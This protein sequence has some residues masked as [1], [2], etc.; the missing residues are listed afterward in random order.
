MPIVPLFLGIIPSLAARYQAINL[1]LLIDLFQTVVTQFPSCMQLPACNDF[2][3]VLLDERVARGM[4]ELQHGDPLSIHVVEERRERDRINGFLDIFCFP[5]SISSWRLVS[6]FEHLRPVR[7]LL[8]LPFPPCVFS[9]FYGSPLWS[10]HHL[11]IPRCFLF[12][13]FRPM[14]L[15]DH[16]IAPLV[17]P[18]LGVLQNTVAIV[19]A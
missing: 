17:S 14:T 15:F 16:T 11:V 9:L 6:P 10:T 19:S 7:L 3:R 1:M 13:Q 5:A 8:L 2:I 12:P 4:R 18:S